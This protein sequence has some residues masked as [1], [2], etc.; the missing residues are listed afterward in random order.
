MTQPKKDKWLLP[1]FD[2]TPSKTPIKLK[3]SATMT[4]KTSESPPKKSLVRKYS[5]ESLIKKENIS[6]LSELLFACDPKSSLDLSVSRQKQQEISAWLKGKTQRGKPNILIISGPSGCGKT[7]ALKVLAEEHAFN[8][9]EWIT[10]VD[11]LMDENNRIMR[12]GDKFEEFLIRATRYN[13]V[14][15]NISRRLLIVKELPNVFVD[16]KNGFYSVLEKYIEYGREPLVFVHTET[17]NSRLMQTLFA[18]NIRERFAIEVININSTTQAAMKKMLERVAKILN[19]K[20]SHF[21]NVTQDKVN[22]V[23]SNN[24]GDVR[25]AVLNLVFSSLKVPDNLAKSE[26][27]GREETLSLLHG[28]GRVINP[29]RIAE[30]KSWKFVHDPDDIAS[31]FQS[32]ATNFVHFLHANYLNT[33]R[34]IDRAEISADILSL[35]DV[36]TSE[37]RDPNLGKVTLSFCVRGLMVA[38]DNPVSGWNPVKKPQSSSV[39][40]DRNL[41]SAEVRWYK[42]LIKPDSKKADETE[43]Q[44]NFTDE[45]SIIEDAD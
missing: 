34:E 28:V 27:E 21:L 32:Q 16:E 29:K 2:F 23:L 43:K 13:S 3:R 14:L 30:G 10:P 39:K 45:K 8:V 7:V 4:I 44:N 18:T 20:A 35:A 15:S 26:C 6:S 33:I 22:E 38:N 25:S 5:S 11:Q 1:S 41:A 42:S 40:V 9:T 36:L 24:I 19:A 37:W 17:G 12:Q 31:F